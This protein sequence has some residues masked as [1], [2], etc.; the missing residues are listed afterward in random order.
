MKKIT[1]TVALLLIL[2]FLSLSTFMFCV[3]VMVEASSIGWSKDY[4]WGNGRSIVQTDD[5]GYA[6]AGD[7]QPWVTEREG[8][9]GYLLIKT[10]STGDIQWWKNYGGE[11]ANDVIQT[12]DG[13]YLLAGSGTLLNLLKTDSEGNAQWNRTLPFQVHSLIQTNEFEYVL[14]GCTESSEDGFDI[15]LVKTDEKGNIKWNKTYERAH[16]NSSMAFVETDD[17]GYAIASSTAY[18]GANGVDAW[19]IKTDFEGNVQ[20]NKTYGGT[21]IEHTSALVKTVD[22]GYLLTGWTTS[23]GAGERD[24]WIV[25]TDSQGNMQW[26]KTYGETID[27]YFLSSVQTRDGGYIAAKYNINSLWKRTAWIVKIDASGNVEGTIEYTP[28]QNVIWLTYAHSIIETDDGNYVFT[29]SKLEWN[30]IHIARYYV[31]IVKIE[32]S[33][34]PEFPSWTP[35]LLIMLVAVVVVT[36]FYRHN[37]KKHNRRRIPC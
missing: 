1:T 13:G 7:A 19:L 4:E 3:L 6:I 15:W 33:E 25:K 10:N 29:G 22:N 34:I 32:S 8:E 18:F 20:W 16:T 30:D 23:F 5:G 11:H 26:N 2:C 35:S 21:E 37:L 24:S 28:T 14:T 12:R 36:V 31:W 17:G 27:D 9:S